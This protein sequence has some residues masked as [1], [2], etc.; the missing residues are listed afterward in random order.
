MLFE[1]SNAKTIY[2]LDK[3]EKSYTKNKFRRNILM[4]LY[5]LKILKFNNC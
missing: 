5:I 1:E 4:I 3:K 2:Q